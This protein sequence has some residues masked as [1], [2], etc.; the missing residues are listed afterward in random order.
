MDGFWLSD[1]KTKASNVDIQNTGKCYE[2]HSALLLRFSYV[3][4]VLIKVIL[5]VDVGG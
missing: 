5:V 2:D 3:S 1:P 4:K